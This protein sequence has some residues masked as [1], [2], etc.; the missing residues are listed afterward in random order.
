VHHHF[1]RGLHLPTCNWTR[2]EYG[3]DSAGGSPGSGWRSTQP[4]S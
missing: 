4:R 1:L 2:S 3:S